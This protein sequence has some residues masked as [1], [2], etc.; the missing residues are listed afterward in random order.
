M[1]RHADQVDVRPESSPYAAPSIKLHLK[2]GTTF[3]VPS[4]LLCKYPKLPSPPSSSQSLR[5]EI[6]AD[7]GHILIHYLFT[8]TY[9]GLKPRGSSRDEKLATEFTTSVRVYALARE[10]ELPSLEE[11]AKCEIERLGIGLSFPMVVDL[12]RSAYPDPS[13]DDAWISCYLKSGLKSLLKNPPETPCS[14]IPSS[15]RETISVSALLFKHLVEL[16]HEDNT[17]P[18]DLDAVPQVEAIEEPDF[19]LPVHHIEIP[20]EDAAQLEQSGL[21]EK[22]KADLPAES[23]PE[24]AP[25]P[26]PEPEPQLAL[27][28]EKRLKKMKK[29]VKKPRKDVILGCLPDPPP[30]QEAE[31]SLQPEH[32]TQVQDDTWGWAM[33]VA[34]DQKRQRIAEI[35]PQEE[36]EAVPE[37][38]EDW[39][40]GGSNSEEA[41][42]SWGMQEGHVLIGNGW[43]Q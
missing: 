38:P 40:I 22:C 29:K 3:T 9:Q 26:A 7:V 34:T 2:D 18:R 30:I 8:D 6:T 32:G 5:L 43:K 1:P 4:P 35:A 36:A 27:K 33:K 42:T 19:V 21:S 16:V 25:A 28:E 37:A 12:V 13:A 31:P 15:E 23:A 20:K 39:S 10:Y 14:V 24:P 11:L 41:K 17:L